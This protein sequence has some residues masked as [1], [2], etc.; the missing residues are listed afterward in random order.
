MPLR[1]VAFDYDLTLTVHHMFYALSGG[2]TSISVPPPYARTE[3]GQLARLIELDRMPNFQAQGG[4]AQIV[5]GDAERVKMLRHALEELQGAGVECVIC[6]KSLAGPLQR[7]LDRVGLLGHFSR[8][9]ANV[10]EVYG[11]TDYDQQFV[12]TGNAS[13]GREARYL[14]GPGVGGWGSKRELVS[15]LLRERGLA[16]EDAIFIDDTPAEV[17]SVEGVC[18]TIQVQPPQ[19]IGAR[20]LGML[21]RLAVEGGLTRGVPNASSQGWSPQQQQQQHPQ[22]EQQQPHQQPQVMSPQQ[23]PALTNPGHLHSEQQYNEQRKQTGRQLATFN[24][25]DFLPPDHI[26]YPLE[27]QDGNQHGE[28]YPL[29]S[30]SHGETFGCMSTVDPLSEDPAGNPRHSAPRRYGDDASAQIEENSFG[31][32]CG[33]TEGSQLQ[34]EVQ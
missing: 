5:F 9:Y 12:M 16:P 31:F 23:G 32:L 10:G 20:E 8:I 4:F 14:G 2:E 3:R 24:A 6:S 30:A 28:T 11:A 21:R 26:V 19:G 13:L 27:H 18:R 15:R 22:Y 25:S 17:R 29:L 34:C 7:C 1:L 33:P